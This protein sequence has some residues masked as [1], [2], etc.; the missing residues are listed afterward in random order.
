MSTFSIQRLLPVLVIAMLGLAPVG[1]NAKQSSTILGA[2]NQSLY[3]GANA[4]VAGDAEEG[5]RL[6]LAGLNF[7]RSGRTR[8]AG[9][10]NL[11]AGYIMLE[12]I[13]TALPYCDQVIEEG[14]NHWRAFS[15]R[16]YAYLLLK[17]YDEADADLKKAEAIA[18]NAR[19]VK[20]VR[21]ML[22]DATNPVAPQII[23]D[24]RRQ[25]EIERDE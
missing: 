25:S 23:I 4:L 16:A 18:D 3:E 17:R 21:A 22:L 5:V 8:L 9:L 12:Q 2:S 14:D 20:T 11:C 19:N 6:T 13:E 15:N 10:S 7:E 24:D 1:A